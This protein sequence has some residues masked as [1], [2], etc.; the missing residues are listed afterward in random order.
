MQYL[1]DTVRSIYKSIRQTSIIMKQKYRFLTLELPKTIYFITS[2]E[3]EDMYPDKLP[4]EREEIIVKEKL[5]Q[6]YR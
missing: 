2:Q 6:F 5:N 4:K 3:L 1:K